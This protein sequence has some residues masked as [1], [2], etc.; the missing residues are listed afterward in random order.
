[1]AHD[2]GRQGKHGEQARRFGIPP[3]DPRLVLRWAA[4]TKTRED[5]ERILESRERPFTILDDGT[6]VIPLVPEQAPAMLRVEPPV[7]LLQVNI[8]EASFE[9]DAQAVAFYRRLLELNATGLLHASYGLEAGHVV[10]SA[11][12]ELENLDANE[13]EAALADL[14]LA[15]VEHIPSLRQMAIAAT[16]G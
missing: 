13:L 3:S 16:K 14:A 8:G 7:V 15:V 6:I 9:S 2:P 12:L 1:M 10:L 4:M 11:A 5:V